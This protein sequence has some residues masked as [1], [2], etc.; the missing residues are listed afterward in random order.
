MRASGRTPLHVEPEPVTD[1]LG[2]LDGRVSAD[3][4]PAAGRGW[5]LS[6]ARTTDGGAVLSLV[7]AHAIADGAA[8]LDAV[9]RADG[10]TPAPVAERDGLIPTVLDDLADGGRQLR[11][12]VR[13]AI[14]RQRGEK[15][16]PPT[17]PVPP[18]APEGWRVPHVVVEC[19]SDELART[20]AAH[21][22]SVNSLFVA[23]L[24]RVAA[25]AGCAGD[26]LPAALPVSGREPG[27]ARANSTRIAVAGL[28]RS[29]LEE[30]DLAEVKAEC[31]RAY[32]RLAASSSAAQPLALLQMLPDAVVRRLPPPPAATV[33]ASNVGRLPGELCGAP[34]RSASA[35]AHYP[36]AGPEEVATIGDG[37]T[38]WLSDSGERSTISVCGL[39]PGRI[40]GVEEL[41]ELVVAEFASWGVV[42]RAW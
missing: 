24:S 6:F 36:G 32:Q 22:G 29:V 7:A 25:A 2:W 1:V 40:S 18:Q 3:F 14:T 28:D 39:A 41:R 11:T 13:W 30:Q 35:T 20:A 42:V 33:L 8:L 31:K 38:G 34:V 26:V 15:S 37:V 4:D 17:R 9:V 21:G 27:D 12:A 23:A 10:G 16:S 19:G 5:E